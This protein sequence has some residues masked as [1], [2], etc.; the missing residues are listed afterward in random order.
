MHILFLL[1]GTLPLVFFSLQLTTINSIKVID[2]TASGDHTCAKLSDGTAKC[3]GK[4]DVGQLS[5]GTTKNMGSGPNEMGHFLPEVNLGVLHN[6]KA[7]TCGSLHVC[8]LYGRGLVKC[9]GSNT[10]GQAGGETFNPSER[11]ASFEE[12]PL[13]SLGTGRSAIAIAATDDHTCVI[14]DNNL[15]K[16]FGRCFYGECGLGISMDSWGNKAN[17]MG[18]NL[19]YVSLGTGRTV[20]VVSSGNGIHT[21]TILDND[22]LKC[23]GANYFFELGD[24]GDHLPYI[25]LGTGRT[26]RAV[27]TGYYTTCAILDNYGVKCWGDNYPFSSSMGDALP[28]VNLG[29]LQNATSIACGYDHACAVLKSGMIKCWSAVR[30][31]YVVALGYGDT[32]FYGPDSG[33]SLPTISLGTGRIVTQIAASID[34]TCV[35][36]DT[37]GDSKGDVKCLGSNQYGQLGLQHRATIGDDPTELGDFL[38]TL[39]FGTD[40]KVVQ[41]STNGGFN[42]ALLNDGDI[43][44]WGYGFI[45]STASLGAFPNTMGDN[46][47]TLPLFYKKAVISSIAAGNRHTCAIL[48]DVDIKCVGS[49]TDGVLGVPLVAHAGQSPFESGDFIPVVDLGLNI[50]FSYKMIAVGPLNTCVVFDTIGGLKCFGSSLSGVN[51][52]GNVGNPA[53]DV[54]LMGQS[55]PFIPLGTGKKVLSVGIGQDHVCALLDDHMVKCW[56]NGYFG[57]TGQGNTKNWGLN[58][59]N[60]GDSLPVVQLGTNRFVNILS[61]GYYHSCVLLDNFKI[62]CWGLNGGRLGYGDAMNRGDKINQMG[63][64][65]PY[66]DLGTNYVAI[67]VTCGSSRS[68]AILSD[69]ALKCWGLDVAG[70]LFGRYEHMNR[71]YNALTQTSFLIVGDEPNEMGNFLPLVFLGVGRTAKVVALGKSHTCVL[72]DDASVICAGDNV[73]GQLGRGNNISSI[74]SNDLQSVYIIGTLSPSRSPSIS[75]SNSPTHKPSTGL[76]G[77][78]S[79]EVSAI[80]G[81]SVGSLAGVLLLGSIAFTLWRYYTQRRYAEVLDKTPST[82]VFLTHEWGQDVEHKNHKRVAIINSELKKLGVNTW[83]DQDKLSGDIV[84]QISA[85]IE[86][87]SIMVVCLTK[88]YMDKVKQISSSTAGNIDY[89]QMEFMYAKRQKKQMIVV[90][91]EPE[92]K[93]TSL[94]TGPVG[95]LL[96]GEL[97]IDLSFM[98]TLSETKDVVVWQ[99]KI[100][101]VI[102]V[103]LFGKIQQILKNNN[104]ITEQQQE[105][106]GGGGGG[107]IIPNNNK[108][109]GGGV[110]GN[111]GGV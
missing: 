31:F 32:T 62:K 73:Y 23:F 78:S 13:V 82:D 14:L 55:L 76:N 17:Q 8:V 79:Q 92:L 110:V 43:K 45:L 64:F 99:E 94:W 102:Q 66:V 87:T 15:L 24:M 12:L 9:L 88:R 111:D 95:A 47:P 53:F 101:D 96:G 84:L 91:L 19:P 6:A 75:P 35:I 48:D 59:T 58:L 44:C 42:C 52:R 104:T 30:P 54:K 105:E 37:G 57:E 7:V 46:L 77:L 20:K 1:L 36:L 63:D 2:I 98:S 97:Y 80:V 71:T 11:I 22:M 103:L 90:V 68:C 74:Y 10:N 25:N 49:N 39:A 61:V 65:L 81:G 41:I 50:G 86:K 27:C 56:G 60:M 4:N 100:H 21:C 70:E 89:C 33:D 51:G 18:D 38:P 3:W 108:K 85:A 107:I 29:T 34:H 28:Y 26:V 40:K 69:G 109:K 67:S 93:D 83:F 72:L 16:C 5:I 106:V